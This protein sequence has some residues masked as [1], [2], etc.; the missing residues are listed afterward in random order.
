M[1]SAEKPKKRGPKGGIKH[2]PGRGHDRKS[3]RGKKERWKRKAR[4]Q[5]QQRMEE[6]RKQWELYDKLTKEQRSLME[7]PEPTL[8]RPDDV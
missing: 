7:L 1:S 2:Q 8:P 5:H 3:Q 4:Q 6:A